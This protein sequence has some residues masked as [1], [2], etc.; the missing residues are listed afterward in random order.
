M[1]SVNEIQPGEVREDRDKGNENI[2]KI[3]CGALFSSPVMYHQSVRFI[4]VFCDVLETFPVISLPVFK[5][6]ALQV[7]V[8]CKRNNLCFI[9]IY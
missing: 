3:N 9:C 2:M 8:R 6:A 1:A 5:V 4:V 7:L